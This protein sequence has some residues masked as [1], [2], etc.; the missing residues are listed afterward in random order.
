[1]ALPPCLVILIN[2][3][4]GPVSLEMKLFYSKLYFTCILILEVEKE[5]R[6]LAKGSKVSARKNHSTRKTWYQSQTFEQLVQH[7][8]SVIWRF[9]CPNIFR[10]SYNNI[11]NNALCIRNRTSNKEFS[12]LRM[13]V[14]TL[15]Q[16]K[17]KWTSK[18]TPLLLE[19]CTIMGKQHYFFDY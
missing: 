16:K 17:H 9:E 7:Q 5:K 12:I 10:C 19:A 2:F 6:K 8:V 4:F 18:H 14:H 3:L 1:V 13:K 11:F 15:N